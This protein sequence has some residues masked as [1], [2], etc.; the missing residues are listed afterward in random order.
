M[1]PGRIDRLIGILI[2]FGE[3]ACGKMQLLNFL[4]LSGKNKICKVCWGCM[5]R[6]S[7]IVFFIFKLKQ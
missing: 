2:K 6:F 1:T 4:R 7:K 3:N 5:R